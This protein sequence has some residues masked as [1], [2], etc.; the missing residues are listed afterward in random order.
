MPRFDGTGP[1]GEGPRTGKERG[2]CA[3]EANENFYGYGYGCGFRRR[4]F[5]NINNNNQNYPKQ[6]RRNNPN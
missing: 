5:R 6:I 1:R 3:D 4:C 2:N